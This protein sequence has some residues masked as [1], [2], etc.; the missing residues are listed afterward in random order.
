MGIRD[1]HTLKKY[2]NI[3]WEKFAKRIAKINP[4]INLDYEI[5]MHTRHCEKAE[6]VLSE[7]Y[8]EACELEAMIE[9]Y[10]E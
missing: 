6:E 7:V 4:N 1:E 3:D 10:K 5:L 2:G 9:K 8:K